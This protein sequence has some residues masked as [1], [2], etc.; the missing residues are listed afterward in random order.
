MDI[1]EK[2]KEAETYRSMGL[3]EESIL[4]YEEI[5]S[6]EKSLEDTIRT[7]LKSTIAD[8]REELESLENGEENTV[9][10]EEIAIIR[11]TLPMTDGVPDILDSAS[12]FM[13][14]G[15]YKEAL[16]DYEKLLDDKSTWKDVLQDLATCL[17][18]C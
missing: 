11:D 1:S 15:L 18:K 17:L 14:L 8:I 4:I 10:E 2:V 3:L 7:H 5:L 16:S 12:A 13:E 9:S 6:S